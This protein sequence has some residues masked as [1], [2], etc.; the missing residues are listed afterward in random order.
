MCDPATIGVSAVMVGA[1]LYSAQQ[2]R[3]A[4]KSQEQYYQFL[5]GLSEKNRGE[6]L[7][8]GEEN[9]YFAQEEGVRTLKD[10]QDQKDVFRGAQKTAMAASGIQGAT[11]EDIILDSND[12]M[13]MDEL[14]IQYNTEMNIYNAKRGAQIQGNM[15]NQQANQYRFQGSMARIGGDMQSFGTLLSGGAQTAITGHN[16]YS[17]SGGSPNTTTYAT[18]PNYVAPRNNGLSY[19]QGIA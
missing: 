7:A 15:L 16:I 13:R 17:K 9:A 3:E 11:A 19:G 12:R 1:T 2:Q 14:A 4:G 10:F 8:Q 6:A 5:A 18:N